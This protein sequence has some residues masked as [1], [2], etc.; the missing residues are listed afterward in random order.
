MEARSA[1]IR[2]P[3]PHSAD[4]PSG[5]QAW[6]TC[7]LSIENLRK[8]FRPAGQAEVRAVDDVSLSVEPGRLLTMLGP[9]GCGKTT[10]LRCLAG[11][12]RPEAG[13]I[14]IGDTTVFDSEK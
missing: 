2:D 10:T 12:E 8:V 9:S 5:L 1:A 14:V 7:M 3:L 6:E 13:R 4:A 11:L